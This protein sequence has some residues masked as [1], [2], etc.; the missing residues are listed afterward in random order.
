LIAFSFAPDFAK[1]KANGDLIFP[2]AVD[3]NLGF[4]L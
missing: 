2:L 4:S 1:E 3:G